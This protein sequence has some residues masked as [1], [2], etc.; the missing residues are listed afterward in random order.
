[1][2]WLGNWKY[3]KE[4]EITGSAGAGTDYQVKLKVGESSGSSSYDFHVEGHAI[5]PSGRGKSGDLIF[6]ADDGISLIPFWTE[7]VAGES[8]NRVAEIWVKVAEDL[9]TDKTIYCYYG[10][11]DSANN[12]S[13]VDTFILFDEF[14]TLTYDPALWVKDGT[15]DLD[16]GY[17]ILFTAGNGGQ[18]LTTDGEY[19]YFG[20]SN[21]SG[22]DGTI[23]KYD[24]SGNLQTSFAAPPHAAGG[25]YRI[26]NDTILFSSGASE[27]PVV[28]EISK[29]GAKIQSWDFSGEGYNRG[30]LVVYKDVDRIFLFTSDTSN[31]FKIKEYQINSDGTWAGVG[32]E[33]AHTALGVP[34]GLTY[35]DGFIYYLYDNGIA[36]LQ[37][38]TDASISIL[39]TLPDIPGTE[40]EG[41][42]HIG[43]SLYYG[44]SDCNIRRIYNEIIIDISSAST[45]LRSQ[46]A[47]GVNTAF[48]PKTSVK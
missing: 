28:W 34:Q 19:F 45:Y 24:F 46:A 7:K 4:I 6:T 39:D 14:E 30:A 15:G 3:R 26:D 44:D 17:G 16:K 10:N 8:P 43:H 31:N 13:G 9:G 12:A 18:G 40:R 33:Y 47:Y 37:L 42:T 20:Q 32:V 29:T 5:F 21:G 22:V 41:L 48:R 25:S 27:A 36:K 23:Y 11:P 35:L 38:N 1:M 2:S